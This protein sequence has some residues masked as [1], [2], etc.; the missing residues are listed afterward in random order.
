MAMIVAVLAYVQ[1]S[2]PRS[3]ARNEVTRI[4]LEL[5]SVFVAFFTLNV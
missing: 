4:I 3:K 2:W 5:S 1:V